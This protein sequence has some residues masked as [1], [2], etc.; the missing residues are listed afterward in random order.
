MKKSIVLSLV[1]LVLAATGFAQESNYQL[2]SHILN[3]NS[4]RPAP[5][6]KITLFKQMEGE[7]WR[8][9]EEKQTDDNGRVSDFL[10]IEDNLHSGI[11]KLRFHTAS[12]FEKQQQET[13]YPFIDVVFKL[14]KEQHYHVPITL[15]PF[16]YSTYRGS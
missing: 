6:I 16:G 1:F 14:E 5:D 9:I 8:M 12:Y 11:Y 2:S 3:I 10:K 15:S 13:F 4:G 7:Q